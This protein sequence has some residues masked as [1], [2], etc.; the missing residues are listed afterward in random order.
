MIKANVY[1]NFGFQFNSEFEDSVSI[2]IDT[3]NNLNYDNSKYKIFIALEPC[4]ISN[5][6][7]ELIIMKDF[8]IK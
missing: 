8:I 2:W 6:Y 4:V 1:S 3:Y 5:M 7:N